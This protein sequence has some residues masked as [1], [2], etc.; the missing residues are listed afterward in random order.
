MLRTNGTQRNTLAT[1]VAHASSPHPLPFRDVPSGWFYAGPVEALRTPREVVLGEQCYVASVLARRAAVLDG[2]C[3]HFGARLARGEVVDGCLQCP[4]HGWRFREDGS[5]D[6][7]PT[8]DRPPPWARVTSYPVAVVGGHLFFHTDRD[9]A[10]EMPFFKA[11]SDDALVSAPPFAFDVNIPWWL[12]SANGFDGQH[13][14]AAHDRRLLDAPQVIESGSD[15]EARATFEVIGTSWRDRVTRLVA[16]PRAEMHVRSAGGSLVFVTSRTNRRETF[17]LVSI[18]PRTPTS[19][20]VWVVV[21]TH[22]R[23]GVLRAGD[24]LDVYLRA[25]FIRA[26]VQADIIASDGLS[27]QPARAIAADALLSRYL[28][29]LSA[30]DA[31]SRPAEGGGSTSKAEFP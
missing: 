27:Y 24:A 6:S 2:R 1:D 25:R 5:C 15:F 19:A 20:R 28:A 17:G 8:G 13:F 12:A 7:I 21:W 23:T 26:F 14:A 10:Q 18:H 9:H 31:A 3:P 4:M 22:A 29:W 30:R 16:G 11:V